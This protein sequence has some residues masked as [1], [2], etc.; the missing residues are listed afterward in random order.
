MSYKPPLG[1][2]IVAADS[3]SDEFDAVLGLRTSHY[4][5]V[6]PGS[7]AVSAF[8]AYGSTDSS[9]VYR[10]PLT[11]T[12]TAYGLTATARGGATP[13]HDATNGMRGQNGS[14][15]GCCYTLQGWSAP[16]LAALDTAGQVTFQLQKNFI[17]AIA[18]NATASTGDTLSAAMT[19]L[20]FGN[21]SND[22]NG[23]VYLHR[24]TTGPARLFTR[25]SNSSGQPYLNWASA[26][27]GG[28]DTGYFTTVGMSDWVTVNIGWWNDSGTLRVVLAIDG[29]VY[30]QA[31]RSGE[32]GS[33]TFEA[34]SLGGRASW[35]FG[36][37]SASEYMTSHWMRNLQIST[38]APTI[39]TLQT[40]ALARIGILSDSIIGSPEGAD[41]LTVRGTATTPWY[42][43]GLT[44]QNATYARIHRALERGGV[45]CSRLAVGQ[46]GGDTLMNQ[47]GAWF[48]SGSPTARQ[49][50]KTFDPTTLVINGGSNDVASA[51]ASADFLAACLD[52]A[53]FFVGAGGYGAPT[54][55][56]TKILFTNIMDRDAWT[57]GQKTTADR[58]RN[59]IGDIPA[60]W[61]AA[62]PAHAGRCGV[63]D[64]FTATS[65]TTSYTGKFQG[66]N[67]H[68]G[69]QGNPDL[70]DAIGAALVR[71]AA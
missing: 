3:L 18:A 66:D 25:S 14:G 57:A 8:L 10:H 54:T 59:T 15:T 31:T 38:T 48:G 24:F 4:G 44:R 71:L 62:Y 39:P 58:L 36:F 55:V 28:G 16:T 32:S 17:G 21:A 20:A 7:T 65:G 5:V 9:V 56:P 67:I 70:G 33:A 11:S 34:I 6:Q 41:A 19:A 46:N 37:A 23:R 53:A 60:A 30:A 2:M 27:P 43:T 40:G 45:R 61:N 68:P 49:S 63:I 64:I 42:S 13:E 35:F 1:H 29:V 69:Y 12:P 51:P 26:T 52:H 47:G 22:N 50:V